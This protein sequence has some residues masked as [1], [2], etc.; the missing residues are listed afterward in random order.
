MLLTKCA[1]MANHGSGIIQRGSHAGGATKPILADIL[2]GIIH[3]A[4]AK[5]GKKK[6]KTVRLI[7][8][9]KWFRKERKR[10]GL[11]SIGELKMKV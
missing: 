4:A 9:E 11:H 3:R 10:Q 2:K 7:H 1:E 6:R 5:T 8:P